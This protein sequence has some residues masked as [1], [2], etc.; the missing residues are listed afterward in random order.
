MYGSLKAQ[1]WN[2][3]PEP[4]TQPYRILPSIKLDDICEMLG[5]E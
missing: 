5:T 2:P 3:F 4:P 1:D